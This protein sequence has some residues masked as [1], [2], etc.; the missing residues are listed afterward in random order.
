MSSV[1]DFVTSWKAHENY[2]RNLRS[3]YTYTPS[4]ALK[5]YKER[6]DNEE[7]D[8]LLLGADDA[9]DD[10]FQVPIRDL[11]ASSGNCLITLIPK[12]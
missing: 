7:A 6:L 9:I 11:D 12:I 5:L 8:G 10:L 3:Y 4:S 1:L 2:P